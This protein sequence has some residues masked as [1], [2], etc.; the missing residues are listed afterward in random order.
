MTHWYYRCEVKG[1]QSF[2]MRGTKL[3][4]IAGASALIES[5]FDRG[6]REHKDQSLLQLALYPVLGAQR[7]AVQVAYCAAGGATLTFDDP[8]GDMNTDFTF[9]TFHALSSSGITRCPTIH[10]TNLTYSPGL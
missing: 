10:T 2:V 7:S 6:D 9:V 4:E 5:M 3:K 8:E 1:I